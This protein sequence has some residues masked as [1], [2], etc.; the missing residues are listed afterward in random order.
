[1]YG[2][3]PRINLEFDIVEKSQ[4]GPKF[5]MDIAFSSRK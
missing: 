2:L 1:M 3:I 4:E 5:R